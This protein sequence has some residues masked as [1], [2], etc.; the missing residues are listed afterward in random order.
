[1]LEFGFGLIGIFQLCRYHARFIQLLDIAKL[2]EFRKNAKLCLY[3]CGC[4]VGLMYVLVNI[5]R[6]SQWNHGLFMI[7]W[8]RSVQLDT[9]QWAT[10]PRASQASVITS[11]RKL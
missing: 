6:K 1:M 2:V 11:I 9:K 8:V 7:G 3:I 4:Y 5:H 10:N